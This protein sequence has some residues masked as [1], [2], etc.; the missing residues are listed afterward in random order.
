MSF[1]YVPDPLSK[2]KYTKLERRGD[3]V[4][5]DGHPLVYGYYENDPIVKKILAK[6]GSGDQI[7]YKELQTA[8]EAEVVSKPVE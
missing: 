2:P 3:R 1:T 4:F 7:S 8:L 5:A 6:K